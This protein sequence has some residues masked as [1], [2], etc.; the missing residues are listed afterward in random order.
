MIILQVFIKIDIILK[1]REKAH[2]PIALENMKE[3]IKSFPD[4]KILQP[5]MTQG[6]QITATITKS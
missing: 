2:K 5:I 1:G 3:F 6:G 4:T